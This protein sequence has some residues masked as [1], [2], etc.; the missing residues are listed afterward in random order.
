MSKIA[1]DLIAIPESRLRPLNPKKVKEIANSIEINGLINPVVIDCNR[2]LIAGLHRLE[3]VKSLGWETIP[4]VNKGNLTQVQ[5]ELIEIDENLIRQELTVLEQ[6]EHIARREQLL[7]EMGLRRQVGRYEKLDESLPLLEPENFNGVTVTPLK[8]TQDL[9]QEIGLSENS[10]QKRKQIAKNIIPEV[11]ESLRETPVADS[12]TQLL[13]VARMQ[14]EEQKEFVDA[15][16]S[17]EVE[18]VKE[19]K[20]AKAPVTVEVASPQSF[21]PFDPIMAAIA[22]STS[23]APSTSFKPDVNDFTPAKIDGRL[24][25]IPKSALGETE[26]PLSESVPKKMEVHYSS[27]SPEHYTPKNVIELVLTCFGTERV[28]LDPC[29][30]SHESPNFPAEKVFTKEDNGLKQSWEAETLFMNPPYGRE[31]DTWVEKLIS[32]F[33]SGNIQQAIAL[34]PGR[35]DTQWFHRF[36]GYPACFVTGRLKFIGNDDAAPFPSVIFYLG[37]ENKYFIETFKDFGDLWIAMSKDN[38]EF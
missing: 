36:Y 9:A 2:T 32:E 18:S 5:A 8:T 23:D 25:L 34:V 14:P 20:A 13:E 21:E 26:G 27:E 10:F 4:Y 15:L 3:A 17:G 19:F 35:I 24:T 7:E 38:L 16:Q 37:N 28:S 6:S 22:P 11:K 33:E 12:T 30:N 29:S 1:V 31:I